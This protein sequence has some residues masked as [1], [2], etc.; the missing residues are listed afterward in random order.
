MKILLRTS[1]GRGGGGKECDFVRGRETGEEREFVYLRNWIVA[2]IPTLNKFHKLT[3]KACG[4][5]LV[6]GWVVL[7]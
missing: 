4:A 5:G 6:G 1:G 2:L 3:N 7:V